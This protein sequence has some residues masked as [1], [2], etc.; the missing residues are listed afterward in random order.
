MESGKIVSIEDRIP[1]L[2][3]LRKKKA[4]RRL[5]MLLSMF[6]ILIACVI[7]FISPLS[8]IRYI[9]VQGNRYISSSKIIQLSGLTEGGS[10]WKAGTKESA[11]QIK[12]YPE[13]KSASVSIKLP[14]TVL[15]TVGEHDRIA[16]LSNDGRFY[17]ILENGEIL[18]PLK[19]QEIPVHAPVLIDFKKGNALNQLLEELENLPQ[20]ITNSISEIHHTPKK[21]DTY[22][23]TLFMNDGY[24]VSA[25][26][27][28]LAEKLVHYP[29]II[30]Q[31][32]PGVKG[33]ID[34]EV[35]TFFKSY[36]TEGQQTDKG[37]ETDSDESER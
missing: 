6:F 3:E 1:K 31:L 10:I 29:S 14:S 35:A 8:E 23:I 28:T 4:N 34:L 2:K 22:H 21:T 26:S 7:Y 9:K 27:R 37:K 19:K 20:E 25:N 13:I 5:I 16:Y 11:G 36:E 32:Q 30:S 33:V 12:Q 24:E 18:D 15:I 17:P